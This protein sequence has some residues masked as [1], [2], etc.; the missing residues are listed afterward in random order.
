MLAPYR[1]RHAKIARPSRSR[2]HTWHQL[3]DAK[4]VDLQ[5]E[6][7][8][9]KDA[10]RAPSRSGIGDRP[11]L[12]QETRAWR[13]YAAARQLQENFRSKSTD[14][15][16]GVVEVR[17]IAGTGDAGDWRAANHRDHHGRC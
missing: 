12:S 14:R 7:Q 17:R 3:P 6:N 1:R 15:E 8:D 16:G 4:T 11:S 5:E 9:R 13:L 2:Q 10:R